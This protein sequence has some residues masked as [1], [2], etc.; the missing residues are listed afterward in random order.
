MSSVPSVVKIYAKMS[1]STLT[2][3]STKYLQ[4]SCASGKAFSPRLVPVSSSGLLNAEGQAE[5]QHANA[6]PRHV[7][8]RVVIVHRI[9]PQLPSQD[10]GQCRHHQGRLPP[11]NLQT[12]ERGGVR[13]EA[14]RPQDRTRQSNKARSP[15]TISI[16]KALP[17]LVP[18]H[19]LWVRISSL[20]KGEGSDLQIWSAGACSR[21]RIGDDLQGTKRRQAAALQ[22]VTG[23]IVERPLRAVQPPIPDYPQKTS[24]NPFSSMSSYFPR[25][26]HQFPQNIIS[27]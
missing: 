19:F 4:K 5:C 12:A 8:G 26:Y 9:A 2:G 25:I 24:R 10:C 21:F 3:C 14:L 7:P 18:R 13:R 27:H 16:L 6:P 17:F 20:S 11:Q 1:D 23:F 15:P 22:K